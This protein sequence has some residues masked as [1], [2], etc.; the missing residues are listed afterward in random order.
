MKCKYKNLQ[1]LLIPT[2]KHFLK[3]QYWHRFRFRRITKHLPSRRQR[4]S[5][6]FWM[7]R[8]KKPLQPSQDVTPKKKTIKIFKLQIFNV[9]LLKHTVMISRCLVATNFTW[10][11]W[12]ARD[13]IRIGVCCSG[14]QRLCFW[15]ENQSS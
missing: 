11:S 2:A 13:T 8:R 1:S 10:N 3:R 6:C 15:N 9:S 4:Y 5:I 14:N 12:F 7:L